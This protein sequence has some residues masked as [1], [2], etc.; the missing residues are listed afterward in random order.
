[1]AKVERE[2]VSNDW[3]V[4]VKGAGSRRRKCDS[5]IRA[6]PADAQEKINIECNKQ[7]G[8]SMHPLPPPPQ[9]NGF[10]FM[11]TV[12]IC[13]LQKDREETGREDV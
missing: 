3:H 1:M 5:F 2:D 11:L 9:K 7:K 13:H 6:A 8:A 10:L 12:V 4:D